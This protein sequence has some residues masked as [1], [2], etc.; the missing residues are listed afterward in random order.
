MFEQLY[1]YRARLLARLEA[2]TDEIADAAVEIPQGRWRE[3]VK[4]GGRS[5]HAILSSLCDVEQ[6]A[7]SLRLQ[8]I[9]TEDTPA[10]EPFTPQPHDPALTMTDLLAEYKSLRRAE[11]ELLRHLPP[12]GWAR[13]GRHPLFGLRTVQW[14][15]E[16]TLE[17]SNRHLRELRGE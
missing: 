3:P 8:R 5:P 14:W 2:I 17:H 7:Y 15:A 12:A 16:R 10:L 1:D 6:Y 4:P 11:L 13:A 9:L